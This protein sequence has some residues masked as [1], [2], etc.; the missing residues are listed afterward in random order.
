VREKKEKEKK[1]REK[2][3]ITGKIINNIYIII[4]STNRKWKERKEK[5]NQRCKKLYLFP[6]FLL[7]LSFY[8]YLLFL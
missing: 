5:E 1:R 7:Y 2:E 8:L 6:I 4:D 3:R